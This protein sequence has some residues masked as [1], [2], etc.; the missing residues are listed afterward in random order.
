A[1]VF[2]NLN[3]K[4]SKVSRLKEEHLRNYRVLNELN[5]QPRTSYLTA[6]KN[7]NREMPD[8]KAYEPVDPKEKTEGR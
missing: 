5:T 4:E 8:V 7:Q 3:D 2:G 1:I 6:L